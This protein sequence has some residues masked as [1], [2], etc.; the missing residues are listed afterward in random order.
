M[1]LTI[2]AYNRKAVFFH[3]LCEDIVLRF[4]NLVID[5]RAAWFKDELL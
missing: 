3:K 2:L 4:G 5:L 1:P